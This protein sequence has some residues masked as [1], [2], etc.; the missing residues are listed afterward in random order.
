MIEFKTGTLKIFKGN[1]EFEFLYK[2]HIE[3][4][5]VYGAETYFFDIWEDGRESPD[6]FDFQLRVMESGS[7][8]KVVS[9]FAGKYHKGKGIARA[10][11]L[12]AKKLFGKRIICES[13]G[14]WPDGLKFWERMRETGIVGYDVKNK[15]YYAT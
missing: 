9:L 6:L 15:Y 3:Y 5:K 1:E 2:Y 13:Q 12:E 14:S 8:L 11:L 7:D 10:I 4:S